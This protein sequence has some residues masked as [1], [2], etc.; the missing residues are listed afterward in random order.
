MKYLRKFEAYE[1]FPSDVDPDEN[2]L[3]NN[4]KRIDYLKV[5]IAMYSS[6]EKDDGKH[7]EISKCEMYVV[8]NE[9]VENG[10]LFYIQDPYSSRNSV[11]KPF[12]GKFKKGEIEFSGVKESILDGKNRFPFSLHGKND[13]AQFAIIGFEQDSHKRIA[14]LIGDQFKIRSGAIS[15]LPGIWGKDI[16]RK[17]DGGLF[18]Q[19]TRD[20]SLEYTW[21][22][23]FP[24]KEEDFDEAFSSVNKFA[25]PT[26]EKN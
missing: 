1:M 7:I 18:H 22:L 3:K 20:E 4:I 23:D 16:K 9:E 21:D 15:K 10:K 17:S 2:Y 6:F 24:E 25:V 12:F 19:S 26:F 13:G 14:E 11:G 5:C 8:P